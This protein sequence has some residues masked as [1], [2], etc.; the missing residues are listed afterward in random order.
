MDFMISARGPHGRAPTL[1]G[2]TGRRCDMTDYLAIDGFVGPVTAPGLVGAFECY[3]VDGSL[4]PDCLYTEFNAGRCRPKLTA[5]CATGTVIRKMTYTHDQDNLRSTYTSSWFGVTITTIYPN[6]GYFW[7]MPSSD[8]R[9]EFH[10]TARHL[11]PL[12][13]MILNTP[14]SRIAPVVAVGM[15]Q[16]PLQNVGQP[17]GTRFRGF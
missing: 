16:A 2:S 11:H 14:A 10:Y 1:I 6:T 12:T 3:I 7:D 4:H 13:Q 17:L 8:V 5:L 9:M 15:T